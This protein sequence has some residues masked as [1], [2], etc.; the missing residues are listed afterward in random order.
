[1]E[2]KSRALRAQ[3]RTGQPEVVAAKS[4]PGGRSPAVRARWL[5]RRNT[6]GVESEDGAG[7]GSGPTLP[8]PE[9]ILLDAARGR[10]LIADV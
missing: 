2:G 10:V 8:V 6:I 4:L 3:G 1:M 5:N 7:Q 9:D